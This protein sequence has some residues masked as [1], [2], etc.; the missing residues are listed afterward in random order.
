MKVEE[1]TASF[2]G[3]VGLFIKDLS[4]GFEI[5]VNPDTVFAIGSSIKIP[6]LMTLY[7]AAGEGRLSLDAPVTVRPEDKT[8]GSGVLQHL[9]DPVTLTVRDLANLM[10]LLSD[11]TATNLCI[12][13]AGM[14][15]VNSLLDAAGFTHTRLRRKMID[16]EAAAAGRENTSTPREAARL[17]QLL[18]QGAGMPASSDAPAGA[19]TTGG[20]AKPAD[21]AGI[22][23]TAA[24]REVLA[25]LKKPKDGVIRRYLPPEIPVAHKTGGL[26]GVRADVGIV[27]VPG[28]PYIFAGM[29]N[30]CVH[31]ADGSMLAEVSRVVFEYLRVLS[32]STAAGRMLPE[33]YLRR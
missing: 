3:T 28:R 9:D 1:R 32:R 33:K 24:C 13:L 2:D 23:D 11:N 8:P 31:D 7:R 25:V 12:D 19:A 20:S 15:D 26:E 22:L 14:D 6:I 30:Y 29:T 17:M 5:S 10:I 21:L 4:A 27:L 18:Y 16:Q